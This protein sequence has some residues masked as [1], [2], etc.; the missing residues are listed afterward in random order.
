MAPSLTYVPDA[1]R[2]LELTGALRIADAVD[3]LRKLPRAP[4]PSYRSACEAIR[5]AVHMRRARV[6]RLP[7]GEWAVAPMRRR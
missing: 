7:Q 3:T 4:R 1:V 2:M 6:V 5:A